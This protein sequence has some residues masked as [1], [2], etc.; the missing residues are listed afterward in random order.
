MLL[1]PPQNNLLLFSCHQFLFICY[2]ITLPFLYQSRFPPSHHRSPSIPN[3]I[4]RKK[5]SYLS[6]R[7]RFHSETTCVNRFVLFLCRFENVYPLTRFFF[8]VNVWYS[9]GDGGTWKK[10][11]DESTEHK[12]TKAK[13]MNRFQVQMSFSA[14]FPFFFCTRIRCFT[15]WIIEFVRTQHHRNAI[16]NS[17]FRRGKNWYF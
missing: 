1:L 12:S 9:D 11:R 10:K 6:K 17:S 2:R 15:H 13:I 5:L 16:H 8:A 14:M 7:S 4:A 3:D